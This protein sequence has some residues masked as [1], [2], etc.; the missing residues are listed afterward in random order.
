VG[1]KSEFEFCGHKGP[2]AVPARPSGKGR[3]KEGK[4]FG[5]AECKMKSGARREIDLVLIDFV[6]NFQFSY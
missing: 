3:L 1:H 5:S 4:A 6:S 2:Q